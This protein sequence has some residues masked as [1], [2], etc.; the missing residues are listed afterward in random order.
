[1]LTSEVV[2]IILVSEDIEKM[3]EASFL[4]LTHLVEIYKVYA[5]IKYR[6][7]LKTL[8]RSINKKE[9]QPKNMRQCKA[10]ENYVQNSKL[11]SKVFLM[12]CVVTCA[13][14]GV[15][16]YVDDGDFHL[17]LPGWFPFDTSSSPWFDVA[18]VY[19]VVGST[20]NGLVNV[21]LDTFMSGKRSCTAN[22]VTMT[23]K[24]KLISQISLITNLGMRYMF[25]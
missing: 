1:M 8:L 21:S 10:L 7:R 14:W 19:Q 6:D 13:F 17:P 2:N 5:I 12:A 9:F 4:T 18:Y 16:P 22:A 11:I 25:Q 24:F 3:T 15:Y 20:V 23:A